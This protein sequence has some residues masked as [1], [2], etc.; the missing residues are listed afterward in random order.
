VAG[1][2]EVGRGALCGPVMAG[3]VILGDPFDPSGI[4]DS[5]RL[6]RRQ[7]EHQAE[8]IRRECRAWS[9]GSAEAAEIDRLGIVAATHLAMCRA[10]RGLAPE[11]D[12][13]LVDGYAVPSLPVEQWAK[14]KG[15][16][17]SVSIAAAAILAKV[18]RDALMC[19]LDGTYPGYGLRRNMGYGS[20]EHR[21]ALLRLGLSPLHRRAFC[22]R[23]LTLF[24]GANGNDA[25]R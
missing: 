10:V 22:H 4:D 17:S 6:S 20:A 1:L 21:E 15:D 19:D 11:P 2:D 8:R 9:V 5:K 18:T 13:A 16:A 23:Q 25:A 14:I 3:A 24:G 12:L 7:R